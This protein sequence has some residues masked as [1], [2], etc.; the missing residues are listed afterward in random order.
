MLGLQ[1]GQRVLDLACG[2]GAFTRH[3]AKLGL[4]VFGVDASAG[5]IRLARR[6]SGP[7]ASYRVLPAEQLGRLQMPGAFDAVVCVLAI[8]NMEPISPVLAGCASVLRPGG[9]LVI[10]MNHPCFRIPRQ[11]GWGEDPSRKLVYRRVD[12]YLTPLRIP[13]QVHPGSAPETVVWSFHRPLQE[14]VDAMVQAGLMVDKLEE[15]ASD[16]TSQPGRRATAENRARAEIPLFMALRAV[17]PP[18]P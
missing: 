7:K 1:P 8:Q 5:L 10:V 13:V 6:R 17:R 15:W 4:E 14:Y 9:R 3:L 18:A 16:R 2:Q 12:R 11:S